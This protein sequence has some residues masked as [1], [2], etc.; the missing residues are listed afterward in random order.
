M[1]GLNSDDAFEPYVY[2]YPELKVFKYSDDPFVRE[3]SRCSI[4]VSARPTTKAVTV[5][6][7]VTGTANK[8]IAYTGNWNRTHPTTGCYEEDDHT[9]NQTGASFEI[10][11][12]GTQ[13]K[14]YQSQHLWHC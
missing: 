13:I 5:N 4:C 2:S 8:Q 14:W 7:T 11:F 10:P 9:S 1:P 6:N 12:E 3:M